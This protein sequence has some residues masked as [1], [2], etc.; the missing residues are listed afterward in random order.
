MTFIK[1][2]AG[3][4]LMCFELMEKEVEGWWTGSLEQEIKAVGGE[5]EQ[6]KGGGQERN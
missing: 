4:D 2:L 1:K 5:K 6:R 3:L